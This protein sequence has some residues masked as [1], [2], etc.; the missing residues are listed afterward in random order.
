MNDSE[1]AK[2]PSIDW[3]SWTDRSGW[4]RDRGASEAAG[5]RSDPLRAPNRSEARATRAAAAPSVVAM[6]HPGD[7]RGQAAVELVVVVPLLLALLA[8]VGQLAVAGYALWAAGDAARAG[9]RAAHVG[10]DA[11]R[12]ALSALPDWLER[13]AEIDPDGPVEV[14][15][16]APALVPGV[17]RSRS[18]RRPSS[19]PGRGDE[20]SPSGLARPGLGR[21]GRRGAVRVDRGG[22]LPA[23]ARRRLLAHPG[24]RRGRG[25]SAGRWRPT[26]RRG[27]RSRPRFPAGPATGSSSRAR[28]GG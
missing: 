2:L 14:R 13:G 18:G 11:E 4:R 28:A 3:M 5:R 16:R 26:G 8:L 20:R 12:A 27:R 24:R 15:V 1:V 10:G 22:P 17:P 19:A 21:A 25:R 23:A 6:L 7:D 9:A